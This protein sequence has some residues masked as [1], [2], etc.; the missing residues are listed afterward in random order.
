MNSLVIYFF[1]ESKMMNATNFCGWKILTGLDSKQQFQCMCQK[2]LNC[3]QN[4]TV[5]K[6]K[7]SMISW[8][9]NKKLNF[10]RID[11]NSYINHLNITRKQLLTFISLLLNFKLQFYP[12]QLRLN[13]V[14]SKV[15]ICK[16]LDV[17]VSNLQ[18]A[19]SWYL[20]R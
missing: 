17:T 3:F 13:D 20:T 8:N 12:C 9:W 18:N 11:I 4:S 10:S 6:Q 15:C 19:S 5:R 14:W 1:L 7:V 16:P 2:T